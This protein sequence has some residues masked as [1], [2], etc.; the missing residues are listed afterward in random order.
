MMPL[1]TSDEGNGVVD[2]E[3]I[4]TR[5]N[6]IGGGSFGKVYKGYAYVNSKAG[7]Q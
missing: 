6:C 7:Q 5:Q 1:P 3:S 2:P 4:Y